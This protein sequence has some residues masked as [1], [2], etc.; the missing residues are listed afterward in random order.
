[1]GLISLMLHSLAYLFEQEQQQEEL[2]VQ[3]EMAIRQQ[4]EQE[5]KLREQEELGE[6]QQQQLPALPIKPPHR[7]RD[8]ATGLVRKEQRQDLLHY[9]KMRLQQYLESGR[10]EGEE[11]QPQQKNEQNQQ[12]Q[13]Q[14]RQ[15]QQQQQQ[16]QQYL[17]S[18]RRE[19]ETQQPQQKNE[20]NQQIQQQRQTQQQQ[21]QQQQENDHSPSSAQG[22]EQQQTKVKRFLQR[23]QQSVD[24]PLLSMLRSGITAVYQY[25]SSPPNDNWLTKRE[26]RL[27]EAAI[28]EQ[29]QSAAAG[30]LAGAEREDWTTSS[31][32]AQVPSGVV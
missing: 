14:Q 22:Q 6:Q 18:G 9:G 2:H 21:Q 11:Q 23:V 16:Q 24:P 25:L 28:K 5:G 1:M 20:Q 32:P 3:Q 30:A 15:T 7:L 13:Q 26:F 19:G 27:V 8:L 31:S 17:E 4:E 10:R 29:Q 12:I